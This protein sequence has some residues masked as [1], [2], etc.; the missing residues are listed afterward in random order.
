MI[1]EYDLSTF[2]GSSHTSGPVW[3]PTGE[4]G[5]PPKPKPMPSAG[6]SRTVR[7]AT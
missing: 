1:R 2:A 5:L 3:R 7:R 6:R 4:R